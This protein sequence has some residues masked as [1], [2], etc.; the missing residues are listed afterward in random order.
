M[1]IIRLDEIRKTDL[2]TVG[3]KGANLGELI[4]QGFPVP[5]GFVITAD[6]YAEF[7]EA[8]YLPPSDQIGADPQAFCAAIRDRIISKAMPG[9]LEQ[10][11]LSHHEQLRPASHPEIIYA[12]RSS[13]TAEDLGGAS[14]AGQHDTYYYVNIKNL[15]MMVKKCWASLW[16]DAAF[17]Y[18][19]SQ[20]IEHRD[21]K[22]AVIV[23]E[24]I[25][26]DTSGVTFTADPVSGSDTV[27][28]TESSWG[29]GAAIVDGRVS[30]DQYIVDKASGQLTSIKIADKKFMVPA[31]LDQAEESRLK[32]VPAHLRRIESL[33]VDQV[34]TITSWA[35]KSEAFFGSHQDIEWAFADNEFYMLQS[36]P[37]TV[38]GQ[39]EDK[40]PKGKY[41]LFKP[42]AENFTDPLLPLSQDIL[43]KLFPMMSIIYGR[44]YMNLAYAR[45]IVPLKLSDKDMATLAYLSEVEDFKPRLSIPRLLGLLPLLYVGY[46]V[47]GVLYDRTSSM[48]DG[49]MES[50]RRYFQRV[51]D[52]PAIS[53]PDAMTKLFLKTGFFEPIGNMVLMANITASRYILRLQLLHKLLQRWLPEL[54]DDAASLLSSGT[55]GVLSTQMGRE[56]WNLARTIKSDK[57]LSNILLEQEPNKAL[58]TLRQQNDAAEFVAQLDSFLDKHGHRSLKEFELNS[59]RW[60]EDPSTVIAM[61][62]NYLLADSDP[63]ASAARVDEQRQA[64]LDDVKRGLSALPLENL[65]GFRF[66]IISFVR[67]QAKYFIKL[68]ENSRFYHIMGFYAVRKKI[69]R[70]E[71]E[72]L[73]KGALK[74]K[75]DIFYLHWHEVHDL[76]SNT[77]TWSDVEDLIRS[78]RMNHIRLNKIRPPKTVGV[79]VDEVDEGPIPG[80]QLKGQGASP[81]SFQGRARIIMD[82]ATDALIKPGE[83][84]VAPYTD[85]AW[86]P[87]FLTANAAVIEVGSYL[88]HAGTI[89]REY[90]MPCVVD[91]PDCTTRITNGDLIHVD[92][93]SGKVTL[94]DHGAS[95][96]S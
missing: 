19:Q 23:Q 38:M 44:V 34:N 45:A 37:I 52:D 83:I 94:L 93:S 16:S 36:R 17:S 4:H 55:E 70:T 92:G 25:L 27:I 76:Q 74:C 39:P 40:L 66:R 8:E 42:I 88:S 15:S 11:I 61:I 10:Q 71:T 72:L 9:E 77:S 3:G 95:K 68:R 75:D 60:E 67:N 12:V 46:L 32:E 56:I 64:L 87:L 21:V 62:R 73:E 63:D 57:V 6:T 65:F 35:M 28:I 90:G 47:F 85:P 33:T 43:V 53:A 91:V 30:P 31:V 22:M 59:V 20:G 58:A 69:L 51:V 82:P 84:L 14:F 86:T 13:A 41:V 18:R 96:I 80:N 48:P 78:R 89:A 81:G 24:M 2:D 29:M 49:N 54:H 26:S 50:F 79:D 1:P 7:V 5:P